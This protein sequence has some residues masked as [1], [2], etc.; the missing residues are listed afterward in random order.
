MFLFGFVVLRFVLVVISLCLVLF[1]LP[2]VLLVGMFV[3]RAGAPVEQ[4]EGA[5]SDTQLQE[6]VRLQLR[7]FCPQ[8]RVH[9]SAAAQVSWSPVR[10]GHQN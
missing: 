1:P 4:V 7:S 2:C 6:Q 9:G 5:H 8:P 10:S 3:Y